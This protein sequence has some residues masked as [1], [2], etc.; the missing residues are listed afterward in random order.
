MDIAYYLKVLGLNSSSNLAD[1]RRAYR[2][3]ARK[4]HPDLNHAA[5]ASER[6]IAATEAYDFLTR[7]FSQPQAQIDYRAEV[8]N[9]WVKYRQE[10][11][12]K[13]AKEYAEKRYNYFKSTEHY[14]SS[15]PTGIPVIIYSLL[16]SIF[17]ISGSIFG[18]IIRLEQVN[19]GFDP[20]TVSGFLGLLFIGI[21]FLSIS[22]IYLIAYI[23]TKKARGKIDNEKNKKPL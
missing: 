22:V 16:I 12:R 7:Y 9:E 11:A 4:Y 8:R 5:D 17:I 15:A 21:I 14:R 20:P 2:L 18:Y 13:R 19:E 23:Q 10:E 6:F 3:K 1:V